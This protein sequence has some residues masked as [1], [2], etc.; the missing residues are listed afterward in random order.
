MERG[1]DQILWVPLDPARTS[2]HPYTKGR[3]TQPFPG[4]AISF[5]I[6]DAICYNRPS[7]AMA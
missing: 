6:A 1:S 3:L 7:Q 2:L 5:A 4:G